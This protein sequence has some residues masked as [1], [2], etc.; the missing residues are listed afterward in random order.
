[1]IYCSTRSPSIEADFRTAILSGLAPDGGLFV[2]R[3]VPRLDAAT[4]ARLEGASFLETALAVI[5][6]FVGDSIDRQTLAALLHQAYAPFTHPSVAPLVDIA[7]R[8]WVLELFHGPTL[9]FKDHALQTLGAL[10]GNFLDK[11][12]QRPLVLCAT[13]G[14]TGGAALSALARIESLRLLVLYPRGGVSAF[15]EA[16]M[17]ALSGPSRRVRAVAG[18][19]DDC[20]R[21]VKQAFADPG[22]RQRHSLMAVNSVNWGRIAA[23]AVYFAHAALR[24]A[25][26][27]MPVDF[28]VPTGNFGNVYSGLLARRMGFPVGRL[29]VATNANDALV[30]LAETGALAPR[31]V[32]ATNTPAMDIQIASNL[33]RLLFDLTREQPVAG[34]GVEP[35]MAGAA[36]SEGVLADLRRTLEFARVSPSA[37]EAQMRGLH[38]QT[39]YLADPHTAL[40]LAA[41][42]GIARHDRQLVILSTAHPA[43]FA[44]TVQRATG[45]LPRVGPP[46]RSA[47]PLAPSVLPASYDALVAEIDRL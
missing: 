36:L 33:E 42:Q 29:L 24:L 7:P 46:H 43:K 3:Q 18:S 22:L 17:H 9:A 11:G 32:I 34:G 28:A 2:P 30:R 4:L 35:L 41:V 14:D 47:A 13:S 44:E 31:P 45:I 27:G 37:T 15:Q 6:P 19:F 40:A 38:D 26:P 23:Q 10:I 21:L 16:Q 8:R 25:R 12:R 5:G 20:Q 39:G 1:M